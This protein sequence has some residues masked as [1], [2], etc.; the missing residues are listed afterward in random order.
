MLPGILEESRWSWPELRRTGIG[1]WLWGGDAQGQLDALVTKLAQSAM[2]KLKKLATSDE[3]LIRSASA[4]NGGEASANLPEKKPSLCEMADMISMAKRQAVDEG[5]FWS[6]LLGAGLPKLKALVRT[7]L[8]RDPGT[9]NG[10]GCLAALL[11]HP[12]SADPAFLRKNAFRLLQL[13]RFHLAAA[14]FMLSESYADAAQVVAN[15][16]GDL[17][18]MLVLTRK[19]REAATHV[20]RERVRE[21]RP[22]GDDPWREFLV[23][24]HLGDFET[25]RRCADECGDA[26]GEG[27]E[28]Q[29]SEA[30]GE[31]ILEVGET[32]SLFDGVFRRSRPQG[33]E[34]R[35]VAEILMSGQ[36]RHGGSS[37]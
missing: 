20:L 7:G 37:P 21:S 23:A 4:A 16:L 10:S 12:K 24:W 26:R 32:E 30:R 29:H 14:V 35:A 2:A 25:A 33:K 8:L 19:H 36:Q 18:L 11:D 5:V 15:H 22:T 17:Q 6:V 3:G 9:T 27:G 31:D 1:W 28:R 13:H 34:L